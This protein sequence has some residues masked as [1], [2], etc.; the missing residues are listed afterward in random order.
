MKSI[1]SLCGMFTVALTLF[2]APSFAVDVDDRLNRLEDFVRKQEQTIEQQQTTINNLKADLEQQKGQ[3][4]SQTPA[5]APQTT[6]G[7]GLFGGSAFTN[8][9]ISVVLDMFG[10]GSNLTNDEL[11]NRGITGFT[12]DGLE[13]RKGFNLRAAEVFLFAP[14]DS[15]FNLYT[16]IPF[17]EDGPELEEAYVVTTALPEGFQA[18][19]GK[20]KSNF[21]RLNAQHPH[22]WD[23]WDIALPYRAFLGGEGMGGE[24]GLQLTWLP[25]LPFYTLI[26]AEVLQ[27]E[28]P[29]LFGADAKEGPHAY[30][31]FMKS[32]VDT[33]DYSTLYFG[34]SAVFGK[35]RTQS[36]I[37]DEEVTGKSALY[38]LEA[39]WKWKPA[40]RE[41]LTIQ[42]EYLVLVQRGAWAA[43]T[44][45]A[46]DSLLRKQ[47]GFYIQSVYRKDRWGIGVRYEALDILYDTLEL[48]GVQQ[49]AGGKPH[50]E[51]ASLEYNMSEFSRMRLQYNHDRTDM[52]TRRTNNEVI[53]Q[54]NFSIGAHAAH[55]FQEDTMRRLFLAV[56]F[57]M[58]LATSAFA[59]VNLV[60]TLPWIGSLA[61]EIGKDK[62]NVTV[63]VKPSQDPHLL[64]AKPGM[65]LA[66]RKADVFMYNGLD[67]EIGYLPR[68]LE[69]SKNPGIHARQDRQ[70]RLLAIRFGRG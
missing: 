65:I 44:T 7:S 34:P 9:N 51:T 59:G 1:I 55:S 64:E 70:F 2:A 42:S 24:K 23:F 39:V 15:Y 12:T 6:K 35:T 36:V 10:Y 53:V 61:R 33:S 28:N 19:G 56:A 62:V 57:F 4:S 21:S 50:R 41:A 13:Q 16:N 20:F 30:A 3:A 58:T 18:K 68:I 66:A 25:A 54:F 31:L 32:S 29:L 11:A 40:S 63:L 22:A 67:L 43:L 26:G 37:P 52:T 14:V 48:G 49:D 8:P 27:G 47:D 45:A 17:T 46:V 5:P 38:G 69:S 60:A